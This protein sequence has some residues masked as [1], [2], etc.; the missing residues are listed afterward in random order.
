[1]LTRLILPPPSI[2]PPER[3]NTSMRPCPAQSNNSR[4]PSVK[5][6][7]LRLC[8]SETYG[9][10]PPFFSRA[11]SAAVAGI[12]EALPTATWRLSPISEAITSVSNS[13][14]RKLGGAAF[15]HIAPQVL[16]ESV[17]RRR[18][19]GIFGH[20]RGIERIVIG[21]AERPG[22]ALRDRDGFDI[23]PRQGAGGG[24]RVVEQ[25]GVLHRL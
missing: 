8:S 5:K 9:R 1:M 12:G 10:A 2:W 25:I 4:A 11:N 22:A 21:Q 6:L 14:S 13:S 7:C 19:L 17:G 15:M 18:K 20:V 23:K 3:K 16:V 24:H